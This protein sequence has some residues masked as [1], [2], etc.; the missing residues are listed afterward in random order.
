MQISKRDKD[1]QGFLDRAFSYGG[2]E[3]TFAIHWKR[4]RDY[5]YNPQIYDLNGKNLIRVSGCGYDK[6]SAALAEY[7]CNLPTLEENDRKKIRS[8]GGSG[9][10]NVLRKLL[11]FGFKLEPLYTDSKVDVYKVVMLDSA[12][13]RKDENDNDN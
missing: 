4:S 13:K 10:A 12:K 9:E 8:T 3:H 11:E 6:R 7:L 1:I 5:G 2:T